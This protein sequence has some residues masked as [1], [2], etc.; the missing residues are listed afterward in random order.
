MLADLLASLNFLHGM[1][2][3]FYMTPFTYLLGRFSCPPNMSAPSKAVPVLV[4]AVPHT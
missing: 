2:P 3:V 1:G 4:T